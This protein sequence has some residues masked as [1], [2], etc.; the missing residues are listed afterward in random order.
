MFGLGRAA[1]AIYVDA[2]PAFLA[3]VILLWEG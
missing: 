3:F 2:L 1:V